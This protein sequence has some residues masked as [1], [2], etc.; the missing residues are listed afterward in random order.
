MTEDNK[1]R[2]SPLDVIGADLLGIKLDDSIAQEESRGFNQESVE[3]DTNKSLMEANDRRN[4]TTRSTFHSLFIMGLRVVGIS[5]I[6]IFVVRVLHIILPES[7]HWMSSTTIQEVDKM[8]FS[9][10]VGA[11]IIKYLGPIINEPPKPSKK[12]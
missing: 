3:T 11:A 1:K 4:E 8:M 10:A 2:R 5:L 12:K 6:L 9:G 7:W